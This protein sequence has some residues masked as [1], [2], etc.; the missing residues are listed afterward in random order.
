M[1]KLVKLASQGGKIVT[2]NK[3]DHEK[4]GLSGT[5]TC[6]QFAQGIHG[7]LSQRELVWVYFEG[8]AHE[9]ALKPEE[10]RL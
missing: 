4:D 5:L 3:P 7:K 2:I 10:I 9:Y 6:I 8:D 1:S